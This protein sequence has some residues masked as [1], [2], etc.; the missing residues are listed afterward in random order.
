MRRRANGE[1]RPTEAIGVVPSLG[2]PG[3]EG[4]SGSG[5]IRDTEGRRGRGRLC[6]DVAGEYVGVCVGVADEPEEDEEDEDEV[7]ERMDDRE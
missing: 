1:L 5:R 7:A 2:G 6:E 4:M 3:A